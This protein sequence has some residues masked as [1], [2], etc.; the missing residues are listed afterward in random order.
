MCDTA[1]RQLVWN[2]ALA[3]LHRM[4]PDAHDVASRI[5]D[6]F[7]DETK[8]RRSSR[9]V[10]EEKR[11]A[12]KSDLIKGYWTYAEIRERHVVGTS[13]VQR[14]AKELRDQGVTVH[15]V[16]SRNGGRRFPRHASF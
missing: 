10:S 15:T 12:I 5:A 16:G 7:A 13:T 3:E 11:A 4:I 2:S 9:I 6:R 8:K 1:I 14:L